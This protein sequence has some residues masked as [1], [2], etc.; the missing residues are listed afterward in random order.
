M[1]SFFNKYYFLIVKIYLLFIIIFF[2]VSLYAQGEAN[3][4]YFGVNAGLNFN[5][6]PPTPLL[7]LPSGTFSSEGSSTISDSNGNLLFYSNGEKVWNKLH[8]VM[9]N[10][11]DLAGHNSSTQ[12]SAIIP[13]P[14]TFNSVENRFDKYFLVTVDDYI[15]NLNPIDDKGVRFSEIDMTLDNGLGAVTL[16]KNT[17]LFGTTTTEKVCVVPHS[18]GCDFWVI[19]KVVDSADFYAYHISTNGFD[20]TPIISSTSFFVDARPGQMKASSN[21]K[22]LSYVVPP[23]SIYGGFYIFNFDNST[24]LI[25]EK[26]ADNTANENQYGTEFS[27][28]SNV[29]YKC[30]GNKIY[31]YDL[32][33][34]TNDDFIASKIVFTSTTSGLQSMQLAPDGKIYIA[35][36]IFNQTSNLLGVINNPNVL[37][38]DFNYVAEQQSLGGR[39]SLAGLPNQLSNLLPYNEIKIE[40]EDC[41]T[42][43]VALEN[44]TN[45]YTYSWNLA[46]ANNPETT[47]TT[48]AEA[49]PTF[50]FP[51]PNEDYSI[52]CSIVSEC[53]SKTFVL[54]FSPTNLNYIT[55]TF[56]FSTDNY[57]QNQTPNPLPL[58][59]IEGIEGTWFPSSI[60]TTIV[61]IFSY[62]F[63]PNQGQ[64]ANIIDVNITIKPLVS[65]SFADTIICEDDV[66]TFPNTNNIIGTWTPLNIS[67]TISTTYTFMPDAECAISSEWNVK[68]NQK[69]SVNFADTTICE[70][71]TVSFP[72]TN[73]LEGI[74]SPSTISNTE[75]AIYTFTPNG[76][77]VTST[78]WQVTVAEKRTNLEILIINNKTIVAN[79]ENAN[80]LL[81]YQLDNG[82][83]QSSN[84]FENVKNGCHTINV[85]DLKGCTAISS[86]VF[87]FDYPK[88]FTPNEDGYNDYWKIDIENSTT[89]LQI[90]DR[91]GKFLKQLFQNEDG[92]DGTYNGQKLPSTDYWFVL[93]Y[94]ECGLSKTFKSHF[95][96]KR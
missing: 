19:C 7:D 88:F 91:Y 54:L 4:W 9:A 71:E 11:A 39:F 63:T 43:K 34:G 55:P 36:P 82:I 18:N 14:G 60:D 31:Q 27:P 3:I 84:V 8:Q 17:P 66:I 40:D 1:G 62:A 83:F 5:T 23:S 13:Y 2:S 51:N 47:I 75:N 64:C 77:C 70:G 38:S 59:S 67:N 33:T 48:S 65:I 21:N 93:K 96:L 89:T 78:T 42:V 20:T 94:E 76:S 30:A 61:G 45:I 6:N 25:T 35:R 15:A 79:V 58:F 46:Y 22:L 16:N 90:F 52:T 80:D 69:E 44:N 28:D 26:F 24:G 87:V 73:N 86:S 92:W 37:G 95:S 53:Y 85:T 50:N 10:G 68:V 49:S 12:S 41:S 56:N 72:A 32:T 74:W 81:L 29:V 57:C